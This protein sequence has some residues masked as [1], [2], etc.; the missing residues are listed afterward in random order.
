MRIL[1]VTDFEMAPD[2]TIYLQ[3]LL[4]GDNGDPMLAEID[5]GNDGVIDEE[6]ELP[7]TSDDFD[8]D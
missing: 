4:W 2:T 6:V 7:D 8:W 3:Y 5:Y 1:V